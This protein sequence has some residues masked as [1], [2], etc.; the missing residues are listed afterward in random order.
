MSKHTPGPWQIEGDFI[1][2]PPTTK[3]GLS[4]MIASVYGGYSEHKADASLIAA[5]PDL[6]ATLEAL[7][8]R[9]NDLA[10]SEGMAPHTHPQVVAARAAIK[11]AKGA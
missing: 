11:K 5:A 1:E 2:G 6:L 9:Y 4:V 7:V 10:E 3:H 8:V